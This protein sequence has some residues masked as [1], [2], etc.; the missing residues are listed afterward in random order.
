MTTVPVTPVLLLPYWAVLEPH[1]SQ[2]QLRRHVRAPSLPRSP[3]HED[4]FSTYEHRAPSLGDLPWQAGQ[5]RLRTGA[6]DVWEVLGAMATRTALTLGSEPSLPDGF[7]VPG[8][9]S[10]PGECPLL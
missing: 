8:W 1:P 10:L 7:W 5:S 3:S 2:S 6:G 9:V 4:T